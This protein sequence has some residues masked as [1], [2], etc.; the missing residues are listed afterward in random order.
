MVVATGS[1][2]VEAV[3]DR[4]RRRVLLALLVG[5]VAAL[6]VAALVAGWLGRPLTTLAAA[7][8]RLADGERGVPLPESSVREVAHVTTALGGLD[9]ALAESEGRQR[10]FLLSVSHELRTPLTTVRGYAEG[11]ADGVIDPGDVPEVGRTLVSEADRLD[12]YV[13][14]LL[15]LARL[16]A[17]DFSLDLGEVDLAELLE[18]TARA[19][20]ERVRRAEV[21]IEV[22]AAPA[23]CRSD[24]ARLRQV[25]DALADNAL[26]I[27]VAGDR[28]ILAAAPTPDGARIEVRDSGPGLTEADS[29][30]AF[31][32]GV[33]HERYPA[34]RG[35]QGLGL[36][37]AHRLVAR[38]GGTIRSE[39]APEGGAAFVVDLPAG[40]PGP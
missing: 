29:A 22:V 40:R 31:E 35:G 34:R 26:R 6:G 37:I 12:R 23:T 21:S 36:A 19:W 8:R 33:L 24:S 25:L 28:I 7:A 13:G 17:V 32:P 30:V 20:A 10:A 16:Q 1:S 14:D 38:L 27:C 5:L 15:A 18:S 3:T 39:R 4:L 11:L 9:Q 2:A